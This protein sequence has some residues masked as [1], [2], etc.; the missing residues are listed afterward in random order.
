MSDTSEMPEDL[1]RR[2]QTAMGPG[3]TAI[4]GEDPDPE[5]VVVGERDAEFE[6]AVTSAVGQARTPRDSDHVRLEL[7][8][9]TEFER[10]L[11]QAIGRVWEMLIEKNRKYGDSALR[12]NS[13]V[14]VTDGI[15]VRMLDKMRRIEFGQADDQEDVWRDLLGYG[16]LLEVAID[17]EAAEAREADNQWWDGDHERRRLIQGEQLTRDQDC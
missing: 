13:V 16:L 8:G 3:G 1:A 2:V 7:Y 9:E 14:S 17:R 12:P 4:R 6:R 15:K 5:P 10:D 11:A